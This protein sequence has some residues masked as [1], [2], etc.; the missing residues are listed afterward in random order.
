M[1]WFGTHK[2]LSRFA[3][4]ADPPVATPPPISI[5][6]VLIAGERQPI[7]VRGE[8]AVSLPDL[9]SD[10][11]ELQIDFVGLSFASGEVLRYQY[12]LEGADKDWGTPVDQRTVNY[13]R[14]APGRYRFLVRAV[15]SDGIFSA[16][17]AVITFN[18]LRP[19]WQRWWFIT[20][21][22]FAVSLAGYAFYRY[23]VARLVELERVR[24]RIATD[25]HD[26]IG[27]NLT[28][29]SLLSELAKQQAGNGKLLTSIADIARESVSSMNDIVWAISPRHDRLVDLTRRMRQHA[30]EVFALRDI[31]LEFNASTSDADMQL[32]VGTRRDVLLIFKEAVNNAARHSGCT[33]IVIEFRR[34]HHALLLQISDNGRGFEIGAKSDGQGLRSLSRRAEAIGGK[35]EVNSRSAEG[36]TVRFDLPL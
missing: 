2:G 15:N 30:E 4:A 25:L 17:P 13:A 29:I 9:A 33:R 7:S 10:R 28:R 11:N 18:I 31:D 8:L 19:F 6:A 20:L 5:M 22:A 14:L 32:P 12:R 3:P 16:T 24:T 36:T 26:D 35:L 21:A 23:R 27:S 34:E 1:L